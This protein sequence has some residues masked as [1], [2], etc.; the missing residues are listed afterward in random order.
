MLY[1][2]SKSF[3]SYLTAPIL[4]LLLDREDFGHDFHFCLLPSV[5]LVCQFLQ[6]LGYMRPKKKK[7]GG[8][9]SPSLAYFLF[10]SFQR[11]LMFVLYLMSKIFSCT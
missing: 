8:S 9:R 5:L 2:L 10:F 3:L 7:G 1:L 6:F 11:L 4:D